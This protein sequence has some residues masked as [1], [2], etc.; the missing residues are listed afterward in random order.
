MNIKDI[1]MMGLKN[2]LRRKTRSI[3]AITGVII[4]T[5][6]IT[7]M[8]SLGIG[9]SKGFEEQ[10]KGWGNLHMIEL[11][12]GGGV[13]IPGQPKK[14]AKLTDK[15]IK[16]LESLPNVTAITPK[17]TT[18]MKV[19]VGRYITDAQIIGIRPEVFEK[20]NLKLE[21]GRYLTKGDKMGVV[22]GKNVAK[23]LYN[24]YDTGYREMGEDELPVEVVNARVKIT[25][26]RNYGERY[27]QPSETTPDGQAINFTVYDAKGIGLL[28][29]E[30]DEFSYS[31]IMNIDEVKEIIKQDQRERGNNASSSI[32]A[33]YDQAVVYVE[34]TNEIKNVAKTLKD[35]GYQTF[36][37]I[38]MLEEVKQVSGIIQ[39]VLGGIGGISLLVAAL[40]ITNTM[41]M[42]IYERTKE[43]GI[44][45]VIGANIRD[46]RRLFLIE[47]ASIGFFGGII[48]L[49][50][51]FGLSALANMLLGEMFLMQMGLEE[52][53][54]ISLIPW[55]LA[56]AS[57]T[58]STMVGLVA[59]YIP[60][61]RAM[62]LSALESLR[63]E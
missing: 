17:V 13:N 24:P 48:G 47:A 15:S 38:D 32:N 33:Q 42:S 3:L 35:L 36:S 43:I 10:V 31:I 4:G 11:M 16:E 26:D 2:L 6:A 57:L 21:D 58:F 52:G 49:G 46:I 19:A 1:L 34:N 60:A 63:N 22:F 28:E 40:G 62:K 39:A 53:T 45:K 20:F 51:S 5:A 29:S 9:L 41:I 30:N 23:W 50:L 61:N 7:V 37:L 55:Y 27:R 54:K 18:Y 12:P 8:M 56:L 14:E 44:M 59:G 25:G